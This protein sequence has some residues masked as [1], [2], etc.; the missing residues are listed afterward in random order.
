MGR[1]GFEGGPEDGVVVGEEGEE[2]PEEE[3]RC[4]EDCVSGWVVWRGQ[5]AVKWFGGVKRARLG[6]GDSRQTIIK[7]A[8][9][10]EGMIAECRGCCVK[11][12]GGERAQPG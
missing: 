11:G 12:C 2:D 1:G 7:V 8:N 9:E 10:K 4:C 3:G 5:W 6:M